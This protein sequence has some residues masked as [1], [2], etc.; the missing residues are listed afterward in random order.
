M[1]DTSVLHEIHIEVAPEHLAALEYDHEKRVPCTFTFDGTRL[2][3]AT[4][5]QKGLGTH[6]GSLYT[7]PSF[8]VRFDELV[9]GQT[10]H[11]LD[12]LILNNAGMDPTLVHE[13]L[14]FDLY[15]RA[16][17]PS[18]R[19]AHAV[20]TLTGMR[21]GAQ[22]YGVYVMVEA[23]N[24]KLLA[25]HFGE[26]NDD[27][28]LF[29]DE[30]A[31]DFAED[32]L[33]IDLKDS[34]E[35]G[36]SHQ[37]LIQ[38]ADF[39][40]TAT[41]DELEGRLDEFIDL[42]QALDSFALDLLA[43]HGDGFWL[44]AHNYYLYEHPE[45]H[46]FI[47][48]PHGM[49]MLFEATGRM[50]GAVPDPL[51]LPTLL[52]ERISAHPAL[53]E[54]VN[55]AIE[56]LLDEVWDVAL[57]EARIDALG[58]LL[59][60]SPH[61]E[62]VFAAEVAAHRAARE[63]LKGVLRNTAQVW[64]PDTAAVCGDGV[65]SGNELCPS[66]C[67]DG[68]QVDGDGCSAQCLLEYCGDWKIQPGIGEVCEDTLGCSWDCQSVI[69]CGDGVRDETEQCDDGN[70]VDDDTCNNDCTPNCAHEMGFGDAYAFCPVAASHER[71]RDICGLLHATPA[72]PRSAEEH[73]WLVERTQALAAGPWWLGLDSYAGRWWASDGRPVTWLGWGAGQPD[74]M[75]HEM[76]DPM[77]QM[78]ATDGLADHAC[79]LIDPAMH[80]AWNDRPC[81]EEHPVV[82]KVF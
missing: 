73:A 15:Q 46:R 69:V 1:F 79:A 78:A 57:M 16:G 8:S 60:A 41:D 49:D 66:M 42:E 31:G 33:A 37:R 18:R 58:A 71:T 56:R 61:D 19:T 20:V 13:H 55:Q 75:P 4:I 34:D 32:P 70:L 48:L 35:P 14:G 45:D 29:E 22:T 39:L 27:G 76:T 40:Q 24:E 36:R 25:R 63:G 5:R 80:G 44:A 9:P 65:Q 62:P 28:N 52:G 51:H 67:E 81:E 12:R 64:R 53:R 77:G 54:R 11:G 30:E 68:N 38:F 50:C 82:C 43:Q 6:A 59:D 7:K 17:I 3:Y 2:E 21:A 26:K 10:L 74:E 47:M 72:L 23:V